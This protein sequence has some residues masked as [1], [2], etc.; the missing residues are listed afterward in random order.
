MVAGEIFAHGKSPVVLTESAANDLFNQDEGLFVA[1]YRNIYIA[2]TSENPPG[3]I[4][5]KLDTS[6]CELAF[7]TLLWMN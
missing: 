4:R 6:E 1:I 2:L 7:F 3:N 5:L